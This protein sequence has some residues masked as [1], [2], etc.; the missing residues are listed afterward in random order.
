MRSPLFPALALLLSALLTAVWGCEP[1]A[2]KNVPKGAEPSQDDTVGSRPEVQ[3]GTGTAPQASNPLGVDVETLLENAGNR[4]SETGQLSILDRLNEP[5]RVSAE[6]R[7]NRHVP[8]QIDT[9]RTLHYDDVQIAVYEVSGG[10]E[11]LQSVTVTGPSLI[12]P[13]GVE[14]GAGRPA[15]VDE[16]GEPD[17]QDG[18]EYV[19][20]D[21]GPMPTRFHIQFEGD[22]VRRMEWRFP[23][24]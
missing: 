2:G 18:E 4:D 24:D 1:R 19:Y 7:P 14:V 12:A 22:T 17:E 11:I 9:L 21:D 16:L 8:G 10:K 15:V 23:I 20:L 5:K 6:S 3:P 13:R